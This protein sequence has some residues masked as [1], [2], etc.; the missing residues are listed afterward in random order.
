[1]PLSAPVTAAAVERSAGGLGRAAAAA[2]Q[3]VRNNFEDAHFLDHAQGFCGVFDGHLGDE[4]AAFC[5]ER[6]HLHVAAA[7]APSRESLAAAFAACDSEMRGA[8]PEGSEAGTTA[9]CALVREDGGPDKLKVWVASCGDSRAVLWRKDGGSVEATRD[10]RPSDPEERSRVEAAGGF[11]SEEFDPPRVDGQLACSRALGAFKFKQ[12]ASLPAA[13]QKVS[14]VPEVYEWSAQRGDW[15]ILAC[16]GVWDT[17]SSERVA[18]EVCQTDG[19]DLGSNLART[20]SLCIDKEADDNL[21]LL[22]VEL[23]AAPEEQRRLEVTAGNF[24]KTKDKEVLEQYEAFCLRFGFALKREMVPKAPPKAALAETTPVPAP[25]RF[26]SLPAP[27]AA[28]TAEAA[29]PAVNGD[30]KATVKEAA[31]PALNGDAKAKAKEAEPATPPANELHPLIIC[32]PSGVGKGTLIELSKAAFPGRLGFS[33]SHTTRAPRP[34]EV[35]G[36]AYHFVDLET[37]KREVEETGKFLEHAH[38]H[39]NI[40]GTSK[41]AVEAVRASG[42]ICLLDI[43]VQGAQKVKASGALPDAKYLFIAPPNLEELEK[44]L[45]GRGTE[46]EDK[47]QTRLKNAKGEIEFCEQN[48]D[49]FDSVLTNVDLTAATRELLALLRGWYPS[50]TQQMKVTAQRSTAFYIRSARELLV[51][52]PGR[53]APSELEVQA[54]GNAIPAAA[55]VQQALVSDGH[56]VV[57]VETGLVEVVS[58]STK[59][60]VQTA[61][62][63]VI[64]QRAAPKS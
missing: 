61:R 62:I 19:D 3:G 27:A 17:F 23:G 15:L 44:R 42:Q 28:M 5:A 10:H 54:L 30:V 63:S 50:L 35:D 51:D 59:Q 13:G 16:D 11:V 14:S 29:A 34:G 25:G 52:K 57:R 24:L 39:G 20:L 21:T 55:A 6:L 40:Y 18:K 53:P 58:S 32:G 43:D 56:T 2:M 4:A 33:V 60:K 22:A 41:A 7:G 36:V 8:L 12:D 48:K 64:M 26:A 37:M 46:T 49:F 47:I 38:V 9:T 45:R 31:A 1:M